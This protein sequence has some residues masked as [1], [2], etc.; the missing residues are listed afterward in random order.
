MYT[1]HH[2]PPPPT[3]SPAN[4]HSGKSGKCSLRQ[5]RQMFTTASMANV[6]YGKSGKQSE[7]IMQA[8]HEDD[9][10][11][12]G[13]PWVLGDATTPRQTCSGPPVILDA[14]AP[15]AGRLPSETVCVRT[16]AASPPKTFCSAKSQTGRRPADWTRSVPHHA[17]AAGQTTKPDPDPYG[18]SSTPVLG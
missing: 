18:A 17:V 14:M 12:P 13:T 15:L 3:A 8:L 1:E 4:A 7:H 10:R 16:P 11:G 6:H 9:D 5:V 2:P